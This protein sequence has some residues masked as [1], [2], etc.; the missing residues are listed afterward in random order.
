MPSLW[1][2]AL[3]WPGRDPGSPLDLTVPDGEM[4]VFHT[5]AAQAEALADVILGLTLPLRGSVRLGRRDVTGIAAGARDIALVPAGGGLLPHLNVRR[6]IAYGGDA[7]HAA[8]RVHDLRLSGIQKRHPH[9]LSAAQRLRVGVARALCHSRRPAVIVFEDRH[10]QAPYRA[11]VDVAL[12]HRAT[13]LV[14]TDRGGDR[15]DAT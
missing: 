7:A 9:E 10:G 14:I 15:G 12:A 2:D 13:V 3:V 8:E 5:D 1:L 4:G 11:A 6:N